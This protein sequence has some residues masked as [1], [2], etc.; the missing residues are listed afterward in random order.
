[1][2]IRDRMIFSHLGLTLVPIIV[3][4]T[5]ISIIIKTVVSKELSIRL[6]GMMNNVV[7]RIQSDIDSY[8]KHATLFARNLSAGSPVE[9]TILTPTSPLSLAKYN[10]DIAEFTTGS[11][12]YRSVFADAVYAEYVTEPAFADYLWDYLS[13]PYFHREFDVY[14]PQIVSNILVVR[15]AA[16]CYDYNKEEKSGM[17][18]TSLVMDRAY[19]GGLSE[20]NSD[21][22]V[23]Y[24]IASNITFGSNN[25][26]MDD[27]RLETIEDTN[28]LTAN[29]FLRINFP[30]KGEYFL[31][32]AELFK[33]PGSGTVVYAGILYGFEFM[34][35][36]DILF[37]EAMLIILL[38][39]LAIALP[40]A[41][42]STKR[43]T[44][45]IVLLNENVRSFRK[46]F[47]IIPPPEDIT[48]EIAALHKTF[49]EMSASIID[50]SK[51][52]ENY[53]I[54]LSKE[55]DEKTSDLKDKIQTLLLINNFSSFSIRIDPE[56]ELDF[57][58]QTASKLKELFHLKHIAI[59]SL[60][61][62]EP[63][64]IHYI[65]SDKRL[66]KKNR[67]DRMISVEGHF[68]ERMRQS[69]SS[70][71]KSTVD[72]F[73]FASPVYFIDQIEY[74][75]IYVCSSDQEK[76]LPEAL[77]TLNNLISLKIYSIRI[78]AEKFQSE[79][80]ASIGQFANTIIHDIK[81]PLTVIKSSVE[82]LSDDDFSPEEKEQ[83]R[84]VMLNELD[85]LTQMLN[86]ILDF[87][88]GKIQL[89][90]ESVNL[91]EMLDDVCAFFTKLMKIKNVELVKNLES[92]VV[93]NI[94]RQRVWRAL[95]NLISNALDVL[96]EGGRITV[97]S[98]KKIVDVRIV[99]EDNGHGIP[100]EIV[101]NIFEPFVTAGKK[102]GTGLGLSIVKK[103][104]DSHGGNIN[105][106]TEKDK[107][108]SFYVSF[109]L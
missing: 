87:S 83:Y 84:K 89:N 70:L 8:R 73:L 25:L 29:S 90:R 9:F 102:G 38:V 77:E 44:A 108:T 33:I 22:V 13:N 24:Q 6:D 51:K 100:D 106:K 49:S 17:S 69:G 30:G 41:Y 62:R 2:K 23:F 27:K 55:V 40:T 103:I 32:K 12:V 61:S 99:I 66:V 48:D 95:S 3:T 28:I 63:E 14:I 105:F 67:Q 109:P 91:D 58:R 16:I 35:R 80:L 37:R 98:E 93:I 76:L 60:S 46:D 45:P 10:I 72:Y 65:S 68:I 43:I 39:S 79:K 56:N 4:F 50:Y 54:R 92:G 78:Q 42:F 59:Y 26:P 107:G 5:A 104:V 64:R 34:K 19:L 57:I 96:G 101:D 81:N 18:I 85:M 86:D 36:F 1:M 74:A 31:K 20:G 82:M 7:E 97:R 15:C 52:L 75:F 53:Q 21:L 94:D 11:K 88:R 71:G 47:T